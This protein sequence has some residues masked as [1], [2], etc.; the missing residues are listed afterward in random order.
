MPAA[1]AAG[2][3]PH[4]RAPCSAVGKLVERRARGHAAEHE[5]G[6]HAALH[7]G[8]DVGVHAVADH[9]GLA[10]MAAE[11]AQTGAHHEPGVRLAAEI[12]L[13]SGGDL[14]RRSKRAARGGDALVRR[15]AGVG[16][17]ADELCARE[18]E[19][20]RL[21]ECVE[22]IRPRLA[23]DDIVGIDVVHGDAA[24]IE[25]VEQSRLAEGVYRAAGRLIGQK[26][27]RGQ[28]AGVKMLL[29]HI[30]SHALELLAQLARG[31]AAVVG[32][33][34]VFLVLVLQ[35]VDKL[36]RA[37]QDVIAVVDD[38]VHVAQEALFGVK[39]DHTLRSP[40]SCFCA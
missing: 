2:Y 25:R 31:H 35:P 19:I 16:I 8:D 33:K 4:R 9:D 36:R 23:D 39:I 5:H 38:T 14:H 20:R 12:C 3:R 17:R 34:Q 27:R 40:S 32:Q 24:V 21:R 13:L 1:P 10:G 26:G 30:E 37:G 29:R 6:R 11:D 7:T 28:C 15:A 22:R 18:H